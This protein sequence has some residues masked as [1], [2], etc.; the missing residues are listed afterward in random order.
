MLCM[1]VCVYVVVMEGGGGGG[2][3]LGISWLA[4]QHPSSY[5]NHTNTMY[6]H[7]LNMFLLNGVSQIWIN[8]VATTLM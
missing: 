7:A 4:S 3:T 2:T 8:D 5:H 1:C 6:E